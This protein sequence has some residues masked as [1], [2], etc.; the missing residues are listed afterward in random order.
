LA[1]AKSLRFLSDFD[2]DYVGVVTAEGKGKIDHQ[3]ACN[4]ARFRTRSMRTKPEL[5][6]RMLYNAPKAF[7]AFD[8][9][10]QYCP[11]KPTCIYNILAEGM[12]YFIE[13]LKKRNSKSLKETL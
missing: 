7:D 1:I 11:E 4:R 2:H 8:E 5:W 3:L 9:H 6:P 10:Y 13:I 12:G